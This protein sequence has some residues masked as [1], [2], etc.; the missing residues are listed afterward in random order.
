[1]EIK[2]NELKN[3]VVN[4]G[5]LVK[6]GKRL[7]HDESEEKFIVLVDYD[8]NDDDNIAESIECGYYYSSE[9]FK[10]AYKELCRID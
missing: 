9:S 10:Q 6:N 4:G 7:S 2:M 3:F 1:M 8:S 5:D